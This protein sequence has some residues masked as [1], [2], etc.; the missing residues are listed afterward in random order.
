MQKKSIRR[1]GIIAFLVLWFMV[2]LPNPKEPLT[3]KADRENKENSS[4]E[5]FQYECSRKSEF[6]TYTISADIKH[7]NVQIGL[8]DSMGNLL[9][10]IVYK[11][12]QMKN[13]QSFRFKGRQFLPGEQ[14]QIRIIEENLS[15]SYA[16]DIFQQRNITWMQRSSILLAVL[17]FAFGILLIY[18]RV[19]KDNIHVRKWLI[20]LLLPAYGYPLIVLYAYV[21]EVGHAIPDWL[22]GAKDVSFTNM[23][24]ING[25]PHIIH[26]SSL[27]LPAWLIAIRAISGPVLPLL[28]GYILYFF[29]ISKAG[30]KIRASSRNLDFFWSVLVTSFL[31]SSMGILIYVL[32][33]FQDE[34]YSS[35]INNVHIPVWSANLILVAISVISLALAFIAGKHVWSLFRQMQQVYK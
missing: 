25:L 8:L 26:P 34:D 24:G 13:E 3:I 29:W 5:V 11:T 35:F 22:L 1:L 21:H 7:G 30:K 31:F 28:I 12:D 2:P 9:V 23:L 14:Y 17:M 27:H 18:S 32:G 10:N 20:F 19:D 6:I 33:L 16:F 4:T 15:G